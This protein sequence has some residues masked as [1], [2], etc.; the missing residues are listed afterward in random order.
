MTT[1][2]VYSGGGKGDVSHRRVS[3]T[4]LLTV[5][6]G[7]ATAYVYVGD[8]RIA[9]FVSAE[10]AHEAADLWRRLWAATWNKSVSVVDTGARR[11]A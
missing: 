10:A 5:P 1:V 8:K 9:G 4:R 11:A 7:R 6:C 2:E 3:E